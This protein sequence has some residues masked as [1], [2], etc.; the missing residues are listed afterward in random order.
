MNFSCFFAVFSPFVIDK[1]FII[2]KGDSNLLY[3]HDT[4]C[5]FAKVFGRF[6][7]MGAVTDKT[8]K[9]IDHFSHNGTPV[10]IELRKFSPL[11]TS[12]AKMLVKKRKI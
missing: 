10:T 6:E 9:A 12:A 5:F 1:G 8:L 7:K 3:G 4:G 2:I 11:F